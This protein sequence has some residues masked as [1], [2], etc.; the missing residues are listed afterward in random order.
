MTKLTDTQ[1]RLLQPHMPP[2]TCLGRNREHDRE[3]LN[4]LLYRLKT[5]CRYQYIPRT[6]EYAAPSTTF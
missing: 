5:G 3:V 2:Q 4:S 1:W 6:P